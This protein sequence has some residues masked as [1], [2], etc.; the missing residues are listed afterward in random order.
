VL[1]PL[2]ARVPPYVLS[3]RREMRQVRERQISTR[4]DVPVGGSSR[5]ASTRRWIMRPLPVFFGKLIC[6]LLSQSDEEGA[7]CQHDCG[8]GPQSE[9]RLD[10]SV[11]PDELV[12]N[13]LVVL[14][15][16]WQR[17]V[18]PWNIPDEAK[19]EADAHPHDCQRYQYVTDGFHARSVDALALF[20]PALEVPFRGRG[21]PLDPGLEPALLSLRPP[22]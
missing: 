22:L 6:R 5:A 2:W 19:D 16:R 21:Y 13:L 10:E 20:S 3:A 15:S 11:L 7:N 4:P 18:A 12:C 17:V 1:L 8:N 14:W 9:P